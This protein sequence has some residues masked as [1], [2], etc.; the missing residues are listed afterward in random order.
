MTD[1]RSSY[2]NIL[3]YGDLLESILFQK[4]PKKILEFGI[5][6]GYSL[7]YFAKTDALVQAYDI[8]EE[9]NG[10]RPPQDIKQKFSMF[11]NVTIDYGDF[12]QKYKDLGDQKF[13]II[14]IDIANNGDVYQ[15][16][17]ENYISLLSEDGLLIL[18]GGSQKRDQVEW[19]DKYGKRKIGDF[20][21]NCSYEYK[22]IGDF[23]SLTI[24][25]KSRNISLFK[26]L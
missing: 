5:L 11:K 24:I 20:L 1:I 15:F 25:K 14:H 22:T 19:M 16:A 10:N 23:P 18:E 9:F 8:F 21:A 3:T 26:V 7:Q 13:D 2:K 6:D 12:Y 4:N 17:T